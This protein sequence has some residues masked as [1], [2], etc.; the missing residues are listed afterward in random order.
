MVVVV[1][2]KS[3]FDFTTGV[4]WKR[5]HPCILL[6]ARV[7]A[8]QTSEYCGI[9]RTRPVFE[10]GIEQLSE[11]TAGIPNAIQLGLR[12]VEIE[13]SIGEID[14]A[15]ATLQHLSQFCDPKAYPDFWQVRTVCCATL[16]QVKRA[17]LVT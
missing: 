11:T 16:V 8:T 17:L 13:R 1:V 14:R 4:L 3:T 5:K 6:C 15:R 9:T 12:F 10:Q 7:S 2:K